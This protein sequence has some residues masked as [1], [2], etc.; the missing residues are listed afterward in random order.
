MYHSDGPGDSSQP[1]FLTDVLAGPGQMADLDDFF[2]RLS[3]IMTRMTT[4]GGREKRPGP[5]PGLG[6][7]PGRPGGVWHHDDGVTTSYRGNEEWE[8]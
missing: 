8:L 3:V 4:L 1:E 2:G 6:V 7:A 5:G